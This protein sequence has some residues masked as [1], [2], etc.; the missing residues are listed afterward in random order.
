MSEPSIFRDDFRSSSDFRFLGLGEHLTAFFF[1]PPGP[2][3][4]PLRPPATPEPL[5]RPR[6]FISS[7]SL[8]APGCLQAAL[9]PFWQK[10]RAR[11]RSSTTRLSAGAERFGSLHTAGNRQRYRREV[12]C[13]WTRAQPCPVRPGKPDAAE[14]GSSSTREALRLVVNNFLLFHRRPQGRDG[15]CRRVNNNNTTYKP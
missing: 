3:P 2:R 9:P 8:L 15:N 6:S 11:R 12:D 13:S 5:K 7:F 14:R 4:R 10:A 1:A